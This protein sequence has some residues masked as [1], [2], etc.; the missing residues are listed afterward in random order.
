M[1]E[2]TE[3]CNVCGKIFKNKYILKTHVKSVHM[4][5]DHQCPICSFSSRSRESLK[6]H[7]QIH[8]QKF[9]CVPCD[10]EFTYRSNLRKHNKSIHD[11][12]RYNCD[13]C[14]YEATTKASL[15]AH[16]GSIHLGMK[17]ECQ[18]CRKTF[19]FKAN[20]RAHKLAVHELRKFKCNTVI[21]PLLLTEL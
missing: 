12:I 11:K 15:Q 3:R 13:Q 17:F 1:V 6:I 4:E 10:K 5:V 18:L 21:I 19:T 14:P 20:L 8:D 16:I 9:T 7:S 2:S